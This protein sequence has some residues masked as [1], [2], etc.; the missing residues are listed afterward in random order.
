MSSVVTNQLKKWDWAV[1]VLTYHWMAVL[2]DFYPL[3]LARENPE[4]LRLN[5]HVDAEGHAYLMRVVHIIDL[6][7]FGM[8]DWD[9]CHFERRLISTGR[10]TAPYV[11]PPSTHDTLSS[12]WLKSLFEKAFGPI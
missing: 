6:I 5:G 12:E 10:S 11:G 2:R 4:E 9:S 8:C 1:K 7:G 3:K